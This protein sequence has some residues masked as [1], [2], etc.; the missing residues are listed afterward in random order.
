VGSGEDKRGFAVVSLGHCS[1]RGLITEASGLNCT[2]CVHK[3][4]IWS[5]G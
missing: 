1:N 4:F 3:T 2:F 5:P